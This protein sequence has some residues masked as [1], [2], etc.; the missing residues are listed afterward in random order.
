MKQS[1]NSMVSG[2][3]PRQLIL[4][5]LPIM[6][7]NFLQQLYSTIDGVIVGRYVGESALASVGTCA[8]LTILYLA[9]AIGLSVGC[10]V[11]VA[12]Y[13]GAKEEREVGQSAYTGIL[14]LAGI[15]LAMS[16]VGYFA[17]H[18][19]LKY[20]LAVPAEQLAGATTYLKVYSGGLIF[21]FIY[22]I[23]ASVLRAVG[24]SRATLYFL[25]IS[26]GMNVVLDYIFIVP[27]GKGIFGAALA[28]VIA[29]AAAAIVSLI[30]LM[31]RYPWMAPKQGEL[32]FQSEKAVMILKL[33]VP[34]TLQ[35]AALSAGNVLLQRLINSFGVAVMGGFTAGT[36]IESY[37]VITSL[38]FAAAMA[39]FTGQNIGAK[40]KER[41]QQG[42]RVTLVLSISCCIVL[43][44]IGFFFAEPLVRLFGVEG[45]ALQMGITYLR[46]VA[47][48]FILFS[49]Y[50]AFVGFL[51]GTGDVGFTAMC[52]LSSLAMR[53]VI[54]YG[55]VA[56]TSL[57][58]RSLCLSMPIAWVFVTAICILRYRAG[59]WE[60][61]AIA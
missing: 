20:V 43:S 2:S 19:L 28:T 1:G 55:L 16:V 45:E 48:A 40:Q 35:Q 54:S 57:A 37:L 53:V 4:F 25:C 3:I 24:D 50:E 41:A 58:F 59:K 49:A 60:K 13:F 51:Q 22:N 30:Y 11:M 44:A 31:K 27:M 61:K 39:T 18:P 23:V 32:L 14:L 47:P 38:A 7:G 56:M 34:T 52:T 17:A 9:F 10:G 26:A 12:Q 42:L 8:P 36:R 29:Q 21:L 6:A 33:G 15:G 46:L 5:S